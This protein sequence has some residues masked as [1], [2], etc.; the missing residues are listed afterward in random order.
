MYQNIYIQLH[1]WT[2]IH[3]FHKE[4]CK[5]KLG[6][7]S[8]YFFSQEKKIL[9]FQFSFFN[10]KIIFNK[11]YILLF[12]PVKKIFFTVLKLSTIKQAFIEK[13]H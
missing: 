10:T 1:N 11:F 3:D 5:K 8:F 9:F 12:F 6:F 4:D 13:V 2:F 7:F